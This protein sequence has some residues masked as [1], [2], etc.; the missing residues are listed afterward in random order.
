MAPRS[1]RR[2]I[3]ANP[4]QG[5]GIEQGIAV[6]CNQDLSLRQGGA[7]NHRR[8]LALV[9]DQMHDPKAGMTCGKRI[10]DRAGIVTAPVIDGDHLEIGIVDRQGRTKRFL[11]IVLLVVA[12]DEDSDRRPVVEHRRLV[13]R[14]KAP[15]AQPVEDCAA[16]HPVP[17]HHE[18]IAEAE[19]GDRQQDPGDGVV[20]HGCSG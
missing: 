13:Y 11:G 10:Q 20:V 5:I 14:R 2:K 7:C 18:R 8:R 17:G 4:A 15:I 3:L 6:D 9:L 19:G 1:A 16:H 12:G